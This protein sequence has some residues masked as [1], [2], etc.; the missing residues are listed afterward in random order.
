MTESQWVDEEIKKLVAK[1]GT[2][3]PP[4]RIVKDTSPYCIYWRMAG[5]S[6]LEVFF[7]W[8]KR[9]K[10][11]ALNDE[12][13]RIEYFR[14]WPPPPA[15]LTWMIDLIWD[16]DPGDDPES[17]DYST[18]FKHTEELGFGTKEEYEREIDGWFDEGGGD[19]RRLA[20]VARR[21]RRAKLKQRVKRAR[22][23]VVTSD[24]DGLTKETEADPLQASSESSSETGQ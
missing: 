19:S 7:T 1:Y 6:D 12:A 9:Q 22:R 15:W 24:S 20:R 5:E 17:Y 14:K 4:Y 13:K 21:R 18:Y 10:N 16:V 2:V 23:N 8:W 11:T 3:P